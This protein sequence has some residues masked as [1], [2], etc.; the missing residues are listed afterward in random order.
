MSRYLDMLSVCVSLI[1][2][3]KNCLNLAAV[4]KHKNPDSMTVQQHFM[5]STMTNDSKED[6]TKGQLTVVRSPSRAAL[7]L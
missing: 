3:Y 4:V 7:D 6:T 1:V 2:Q 5:A